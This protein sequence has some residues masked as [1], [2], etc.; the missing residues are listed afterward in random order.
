MTAVVK[1]FAFAGVVQARAYGAQKVSDTFLMDKQPYLQ[2]ETLSITDGASTSSQA[3]PADTDFALVQV[4]P[5]KLVYFEVNAGDRAVAASS[6]SPYLKGDVRVKIGAG[7]TFS[8]REWIP[9]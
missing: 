5:G 1:V 4:Q 6:N 3:M 9:E 8:F 7:A 2:A